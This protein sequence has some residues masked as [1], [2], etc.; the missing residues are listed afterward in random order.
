MIHP[1]NTPCLKCGRT[2]LAKRH[3]PEIT[4]ELYARRQAHAERL[5]FPIPPL[6]QEEHLVMDCECGYV[7]WTRTA[8]YKE[9]PTH[10]VFIEDVLNTAI[11][12]DV[13]K[14]THL[15]ERPGEPT[16]V[17][18]TAGDCFLART[19]DFETLKAQFDALKS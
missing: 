8:D 16:V 6:P 9:P 18:L 19:P 5:E 12:I 10:L 15:T 11:A 7:F 2:S 14:I 3:E 1:F 4:K 17:H 13:E